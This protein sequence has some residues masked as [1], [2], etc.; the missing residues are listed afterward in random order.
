MKNEK[1]WKKK[2]LY[3]P[4]SIN[5]DLAELLEDLGFKDNEG[6]K[7]Y[8]ID[9]EEEF[10]RRHIKDSLSNCF[11]YYVGFL[12]LDRKLSF[13]CLRNTYATFS[14][15][16]AGE[17]LSIILTGHSEKRVMINNYWNKLE[18]NKI[19]EKFPRIYPR[20][21]NFLHPVPPSRNI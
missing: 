21:N 10:S 15:I 11:S 16:E 6:S 4:I 8:I 20:K 3:K 9:P 18:T 14:K 5:M 13:G 17:D 19:H 1:I 2:N 12:N 7:N